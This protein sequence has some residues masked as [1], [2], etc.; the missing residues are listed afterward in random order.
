MTQLVGQEQLKLTLLALAAGDGLP[1]IDD[2]MSSVYT[3]SSLASLSEGD[4]IRALF[5]SSSQP[6]IPLV[7]NDWAERAAELPPNLYRYR[8]CARPST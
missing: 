5:L 2:D 7:I 3:L 6:D 4:G 8:N 1:N